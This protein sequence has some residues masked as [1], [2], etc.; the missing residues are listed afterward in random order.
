MTMYG[1]YLQNQVMRYVGLEMD[2]NVSAMQ[3]T[4]FLALRPGIGELVKR[5]VDVEAIGKRGWD[6]AVSDCRC[7][8]VQV[9]FG[10]MLVRQL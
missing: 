2:G 5:N 1:A 7:W 9:E 3:G 6:S 4:R 8:Y 10:L